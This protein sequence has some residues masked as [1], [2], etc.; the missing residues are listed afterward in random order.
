MT[1]ISQKSALLPNP[2]K[3]K[4]RKKDMVDELSEIFVDLCV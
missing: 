1:P 3:N 2:P 4:I